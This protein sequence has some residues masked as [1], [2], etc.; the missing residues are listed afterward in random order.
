MDAFVVLVAS[1]ILRW[2]YE[3]DDDVRPWVAELPTWH[4]SKKTVVDHCSIHSDNSIRNEF[5]LHL[6]S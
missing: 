5:E 2:P 6:S 1:G 4:W 3:L